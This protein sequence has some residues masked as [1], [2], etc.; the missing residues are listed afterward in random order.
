VASGTERGAT[1]LAAKGL[2]RFSVTMLAIANER[3]NVS[4]GDAEVWALVIG[5]GIALGVHALGGSPAAFHLTP[6]ARHLQTLVL[7]LT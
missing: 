6:G 3:M 7:Q 4:I 1:D 5:T 2:D